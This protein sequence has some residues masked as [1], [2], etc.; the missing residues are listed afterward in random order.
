[1]LLSDDKSVL[2]AASSTVGDL[3]YLDENLFAD[4]LNELSKHESPVVKRNLVSHLRSYISLYPEDEREIF[5]TL[6]LDG[7]EVLAIRLRELLLRMEEINTNC[8]ALI[9][10]RIYQKDAESLLPLWDILDVRKS[11]RTIFWRKFLQQ[12]TK[13]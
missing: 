3:Q 8:F 12:G 2:A 4:K 1:M 10:G 13:N 9:I 6:W 5:S 11:E 7:D